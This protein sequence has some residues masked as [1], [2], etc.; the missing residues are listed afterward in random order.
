VSENITWISFGT[1]FRCQ[2]F[3]LRLVGET[4]GSRIGRLY[5]EEGN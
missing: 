3:R 1:L 2:G 4:R 5:V